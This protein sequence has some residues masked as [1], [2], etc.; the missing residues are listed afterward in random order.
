M[1]TTRKA[2]VRAFRMWGVVFFTTGWLIPLYFSMD[3]LFFWFKDE[4]AP[5][6]YHGVPHLNSFPF[7]Y[8]AKK[9]F[10][11]AFFWMSAVVIYWSFR[12][13]MREDRLAEKLRKMEK[14][15]PDEGRIERRGLLIAALILAFLATISGLFSVLTWLL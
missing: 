6:I 4:V 5:A 1:A 15:D 9:F 12:L 14:T 8:E 13:V 3:F 10:F 2:I 11:L 7:L